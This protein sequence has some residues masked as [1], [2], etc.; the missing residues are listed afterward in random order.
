LGLDAE[1]ARDWPSRECSILRQ[2]FQ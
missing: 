2:S 1:S